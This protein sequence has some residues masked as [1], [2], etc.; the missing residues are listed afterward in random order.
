M[1]A[2]VPLIVLLV[3]AWLPANGVR[4]AEPTAE[5]LAFFEARVRPLLIKHCF[6]C[7]SKSSKMVQGKFRLDSAEALLAGGESGTAIVSGKPADSRLIKAVRYDPSESQ[8]PPAGKLS[9]A[10]IEVLTVW[11]QRGAPFPVSKTTDSAAPESTT[12]RTIDIA[13][14]KQH[15]AFQALKRTAVASVNIAPH[16]RPLSPEYRGDGSERVARFLDAFVLAEVEQRSLQPAP[17]ADRRTFLRRVSFDLLGLPPSPAD[18]DEFV[19]DPDPDAPARW[20]E[21]LLASP[22]YGERWGRYWLDLVRYADVI[23]QWAPPGGSPWVYRDWVVKALNDDLPYDQFA[24]RQLA[25]DQMPEA[26]PE[27]IAALGLVGLSPSYWKEL[28]LAPD[29]IK[30][31]VAEEWEERI[32]TTTSTFLGLTVSCARCHDHKYDPIT[33]QDYYGLAGVFASIRQVP[34]WPLSAELVQQIAAAKARVQALNTEA[35]QLVKRAAAEPGKSEELKQQAENL[36]SQA[37]QLRQATPH[38]D[39]VQAYA[40]EDAS[41]LVLPDGTARTKLDFKMGVGQDVALQVRGNP[42][43]AGIIVPRRYLSVLSRNEPT[44]FTTGSGRLE[45]ARAMFRDS[46]PLVARVIVNRIWRHHFGRG[47]VETPSNFGTLGQRPTHPEL[48]DEL[49]ARFIESGWS[50]KWLHREILNSSTYQQASQVDPA[51]IAADPDNMWLSRMPRRR[52]EIEAW[53]DNML[54]ASGQLVSR[55]GGAPQELHDANHQRR[56]LYGLVRR[57]ELS[58][59]LR[60]FDFPDPT[61]HSPARLETTTPLQQLYVLNSPFIA[62]QSQRLVARLKLEAPQ[63]VRQQIERAYLLLTGRPPTARQLEQ[64]QAFLG[65]APSDPQWQQ[66]VEVLLAS[67]AALFVE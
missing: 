62:Q 9:D 12:K 32:H 47:L 29:V 63:D 54:S 18:V 41:L 30:S 57:R 24:Q 52:L 37:Q 46:S 2:S 7:H 49:A 33:Q 1:R 64:S 50:L 19:N 6:E 61:G 55:L 34:R 60:L 48:L 21:R 36:R 5:D 17:A 10:E 4:A 3:V 14:G 42:S 51:Q 13:A 39:D 59:V 8:M 58:D 65:N 26:V 11:V 56:T 23:E 22:H 28:K 38:I 20:I 25:A 43:N 44:T 45:L 27:D 66:Y 31:V 15:W 40:I 53:R 67:N 16:P 35:D